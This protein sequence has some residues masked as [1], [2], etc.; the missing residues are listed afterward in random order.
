MALGSIITC[1]REDSE[2]QAIYLHNFFK[3]NSSNIQL[4][5]GRLKLILQVLRTLEYCHYVQ[6]LLKVRCLNDHA[7][8]FKSVNTMR[9]PTDLVNNHDGAPPSGKSASIVLEQFRRG[10][11][12]VI[13]SRL[14]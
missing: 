2:E 8:N 13:A 14:F 7:D 10:A 4:E 6:M 9:P 3:R 11:P 1:W 5:N 12:F